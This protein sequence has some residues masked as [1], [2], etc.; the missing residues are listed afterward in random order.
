MFRKIYLPKIVFPTIKLLF[1]VFFLVLAFGA[2]KLNIENIVSKF[3]FGLFL[4]SLFFL[5]FSAFFCF[6][7]SYF[8]TFYFKFII[9]TSDCIE[10]F[11]LKKLRISKY[12][13]IEIERF[14]ESEVYFGR[15]AWKSNSIVLYFKNGEKIEIVNCFVSRLSDLKSNLIQKKIMHYGFED[16]NTGWFFRQYKF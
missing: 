11:E 16:Y 6:Q 1:S 10:I 8:L 12:K 7:F 2:L 9:L 3:D 14:S 5:A 15:Y 13:L 4:S